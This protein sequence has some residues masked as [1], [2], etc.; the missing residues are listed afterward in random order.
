MRGTGDGE[1]FQAP[2]ARPVQGSADNGASAP[3]PGLSSSP[4]TDMQELS[5]IS[6]CAPVYPNKQMYYDLLSEVG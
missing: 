6:G 2:P 1:E 5:S 3:A 4:G